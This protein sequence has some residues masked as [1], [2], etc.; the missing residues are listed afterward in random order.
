MARCGG[1]RN[2]GGLVRG[3]WALVGRGTIPS[4]GLCVSFCRVVVLVYYTYVKICPAHSFAVL[5][6][7]QIFKI[8]F[9]YIEKNKQNRNTVKP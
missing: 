2:A 3:G 5:F 8:V 6:R 9:V 7:P 1:T 4:G